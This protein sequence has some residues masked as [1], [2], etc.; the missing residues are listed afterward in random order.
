MQQLELA[1]ESGRRSPDQI[2]CQVGIANRKD[3]NRVPVA[4]TPLGGANP[5][6]QAVQG[7]RPP[8]PS[9]G[10]GNIDPELQLVVG[11]PREK[12]RD[13]L[14]DMPDD[15]VRDGDGSNLVCEGF[16]PGVLDCVLLRTEFQAEV[17]GRIVFVGIPDVRARLV[18]E[19]FDP[20][21]LDCV[22]LRTEFQAEVN[23][24][25]VPLFVGI[26]VFVS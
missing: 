19:G 17:N 7:T 2:V 3:W 10:Q 18:C 21:V 8:V 14:P 24:R 20:G 15:P 16:D 12:V 13:V 25:I 4:Q 26:P 5:L 1:I 6:H 23:G 11:C 9:S 22:L